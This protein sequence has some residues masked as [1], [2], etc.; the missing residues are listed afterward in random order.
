M[1]NNKK[2]PA[3]VELG[4]LGGLKSKRKITAEQQAQMQLGRKRAAEKAEKVEAGTEAVSGG[5]G[6]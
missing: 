6:A 4:R 5:G 1:K 3:A 2:N